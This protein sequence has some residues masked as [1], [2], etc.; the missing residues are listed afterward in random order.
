MIAILL[1]IAAYFAYDYLKNLSP[2]VIQTMTT[3][4]TPTSQTGVVM[5]TPWTTVV[6]TTEPTVRPIRAVA[7]IT[8]IDP[9]SNDRDWE[10]CHKYPINV[11]IEIKWEIGEWTEAGFEFGHV[12]TLEVEPEIKLLE[13]IVIKDRSIFI[14]VVNTKIG[15]LLNLSGK[16]FQPEIRELYFVNEVTFNFEAHPTEGITPSGIECQPQLKLEIH[17]Q[18]DG[19]PIEIE[20]PLVWFPW[21]ISINP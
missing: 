13:S 3:V 5:T 19:R 8:S 9:I 7:N 12:G 14:E 11:T 10:P 1:A 17:G 20:V 6:T 4:T 2:P 21:S 18:L 15:P 16:E